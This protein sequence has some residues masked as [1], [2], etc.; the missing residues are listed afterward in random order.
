ML[1]FTFRNQHTSEFQGLV[2]KTVNNPLL[3]S[4]RVKRISV[5]GRDGSYVFEDGFENKQLEFKCIMAK[6]NIQERR[7]RLR[8]IAAWLSGT[9]DL[10]LDHEPDKTY[11]IVRSISDVGLTLD[12][13][14]DEFNIVFEAEP[15]QYGE[16]RTVSVDNPTS[17]TVTN[18][19]NA[20]AETRISISAAGNV[21]ATC[22]SLSFL[23]AGMTETLHLDSKRMLVYNGSVVNKLSKHTG[24][25]IKLAP[26]TNTITISG[27]VTNVSVEFYDTYI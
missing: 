14:T 22:A 25:F 21:T 18:S 9:G 4:K 24:D 10:I 16:L 6:G 15:F 11:K 2:V 3:A 8:E 26:G 20:P 13:I 12:K 23:L 7:L 5:P 19:G 27:T 17:F 1:G